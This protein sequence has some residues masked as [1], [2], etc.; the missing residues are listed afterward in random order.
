MWQPLICMLGDMMQD[1]IEWVVGI[2][3]GIF[4]N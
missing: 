4:D 1:A 2:I 3:F